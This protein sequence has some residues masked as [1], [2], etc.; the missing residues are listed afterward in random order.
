MAAQRFQRQHLSGRPDALLIA[1]VGLLS[2]VLIFLIPYLTA[3]G[4]QGA[5]DPQQS[6]SRVPQSLKGL[7]PSDLTEDQ[8]IAHALNRLGYGPRP[9]DIETVKQMGLGKWIDRQL[10]PESIDDSAL[11]ARLSAFPRWACP[12]KHFW[13]SSHGLRRPPSAKACTCNS[14]GK[15]SRQNCRR[16]GRRRTAK[17]RW[18]RTIAMLRPM[19]IRHRLETT[20]QRHWMTEPPRRRT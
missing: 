4:D 2:A 9:G 11:R 6:G 3:S 13:I 1:T 19:A 10:H 7:P 12:L 15:S 5:N 16:R 20:G 8:A 18:R 17:S 14:T